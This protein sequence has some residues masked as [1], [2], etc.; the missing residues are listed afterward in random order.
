M[1]KKKITKRLELNKETLRNLSERDLQAAAGGI[2]QGGAGTCRSDCFCISDGSCPP[3]H[4]D[5]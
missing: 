2:S 1:D 5:C 3:T 4:P